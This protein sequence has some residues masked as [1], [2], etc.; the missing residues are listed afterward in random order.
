[1]TSYEIHQTWTNFLTSV[2]FKLCISESIAT[3]LLLYLVYSDEDKWFNDQ[4]LITQ[5]FIALIMFTIIS[6]FVRILEPRKQMVRAFSI[7]KIKKWNSTKFIS[8]AE[9]NLSFEHIQFEIQRSYTDVT[10]IIFL[11][12]FYAPL[13][14]LSFLFAFVCTS[15]RY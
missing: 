5:V 3:G 9:A 2:T 12:L 4:D 1:M 13:F 11:C 14:P 7:W 15:L 10:K 6:P 8:Q